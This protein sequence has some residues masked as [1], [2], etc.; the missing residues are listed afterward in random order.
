[1]DPLSAPAPSPH[2]LRCSEPLPAEAP[3]GLCPRCVAAGNFLTGSFLAAPPSGAK[4]PARVPAPAEISGRFPQLEIETVLGRGGMGVVYKARQKA[5]ERWVALKLLAP[6]RTEDPVFAARFAT[7]AQALARLHHPHIVTVYDFG[8]A[9][10]YYYLLMEYV[11]GLSLRQLQQTAR[12][13]PA[14]ALAIVP[15]ICDALQ[16]AHEQGV[17]H[18]DIKPE[19]IL[20]DRQGRVKVA[21]FGL[22][23][24]ASAHN[25]EEADVAMGTPGYMAPEQHTHPDRV[26][27]RADIYA[28]GAVFYEMLT[29]SRPESPIA[30]PSRQVKID[31]RLD[32]VVLRA[33][34]KEPE[35]RWQQAGDV[36]TQVESIAATT[37]G[38]G[39]KRFPRL[40]A[41]LVIVC[42]AGLGGWLLRRSPAFSPVNVVQK[43]RAAGETVD[44]SAHFT[45]RKFGV[46]DA[47]RALETIE[48][49]AVFDGLRFVVAGQITLAGSE[50]KERNP[51]EGYPAKVEGIA[52]G[53]R[54]FDELHLLHVTYWENP[55]GEAVATVRLRYADGTAADFPLRYGI[56]V[57]DWSRRN[58]EEHERLEDPDSKIVRRD[59]KRNQYQA[60]TRITKT[61]LVNPRP[62]EPV[63]SMELVAAPGLASYSLLA[64]TTARLDLGREVT[65]AVAFDEPEENF[66]GEMVVRVVKREN[67]EPVPGALIKVDGNFSG[68][69]V[70][71]EPQ[72]SDARGEARVRFPRRGRVT[73]FALSLRL[74]LDDRRG[75][76]LSWD[77]DYPRVAYFLVGE[78]KEDA[79]DFVQ[80]GAEL[81][82]WRRKL[83][84]E[85]LAE[86]G[87]NAIEPTLPNP[88]GSITNHGERAFDDLGALVQ[89]TRGALLFKAA[90]TREGGPSGTEFQNLEN[91]DP[92]AYETLHGPGEV[93]QK[94]FLDWVWRQVEPHAAQLAE[95]KMEKAERPSEFRPLTEQELVA[96][97]DALKQALGEKP[98]LTEN[99]P[100]SDPTDGARRAAADALMA[101]LRGTALDHWLDA[102]G[103][104]QIGRE[105]P[106]GPSV[107][108]FDLIGQRIE[109]LCERGAIGE[110][111]LRV[112]E[113]AN[114]RR[115]IVGQLM[116]LQKNGRLSRVLGEASG[117]V[118]M[119]SVRA[120]G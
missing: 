88:S 44:L 68:A 42:L 92:S 39:R 19:N 12:L 35:R 33:L 32:E 67:G 27:H 53:D 62:G 25:A 4:A 3:E 60:T 104:M 78:E 110:I 10:G 76:W 74:V 29:G 111:R 73:T 58:S 119:P 15:Q 7:E 116:E 112:Q 118:G 28:L 37:S 91:R 34:E 16:Y 14:E 96:C 1:M 75:A 82:E 57:R 108:A 69:S 56:H 72:R 97:L 21:D 115:F 40:A 95:W 113:Q 81:P 86:L 120:G 17:V 45:P 94:A 18:R 30:T 107:R 54:R 80:L 64:A 106:F 61:R 5:L 36:K 85:L 55:Q 87:R 49:G 71:A 89:G 84:R 48:G 26:D 63:R 52:L 102:N 114:I 50:F 20:V 90:K 43:E 51:A 6:E 109:L 93:A 31:V 23:R 59:L 24:L 105:P 65:P 2:C 9:G 100:V 41:T 117:D 103:Q 11:D 98:Y 46:K 83:A 47:S 13:A 99:L 101:R 66:D 8:R 77:Q 22:A 70:V 38:A 79:N